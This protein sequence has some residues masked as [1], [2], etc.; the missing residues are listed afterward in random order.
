ME[1]PNQDQKRGTSS[2]VIAERRGMPVYVRNPSIPGAEDLS[3]SRKRQIGDEHKGLVI[4]DGSGEIL[5]RGAAVAYEWEEVDSERFVKLF[6]AGLKQ[7]SGLSKAGLTMFEMVYS[8]MQ[9]K[10]GSDKVELS[11]LTAGK[12]KKVFYDGL[13]EL[14]EKGFLFH[15]PVDGAFFVN[16]RYMFNGDRLAFV[17]AYHLKGAKPQPEQLSLLPPERGGR[18]AAE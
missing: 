7:A 18:P 9:E 5:G 12:S 6:L 1:S 4:D 10:P 3:R 11:F 15:S 13:R 2:L 14:L 17:K 16:I 8:L